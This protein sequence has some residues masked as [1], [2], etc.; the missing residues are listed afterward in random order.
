MNKKLSLTFIFIL[1]TI[2]CCNMVFANPVHAEEISTDTVEE[3][4]VPAEDTGTDSSNKN[5]V[6]APTPAIDVEIE[7]PELA[8]VVNKL[9]NKIGDLTSGIQKILS[10]LCIIV[11]LIGA[12][13]L[14]FGA[15]ASKRMWAPGIWVMITSGIVYVCINYASE[16]MAWF[17]RFLL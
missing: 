15:L 16:I 7:N 5:D 11:F 3:I 9:L 4:E 6:V 13:K 2:L 10:S 12:G 1:T 17:N 14:L 8:G